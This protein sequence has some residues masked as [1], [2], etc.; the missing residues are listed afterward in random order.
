MKSDQTPK[1][2]RCQ[3]GVFRRQRSRILAA[4]FDRNE[5]H[6]ISGVGHKAATF[7]SLCESNKL[8]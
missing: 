4:H 2:Q 3:P 5:R 8:S 6:A 1:L 7:E